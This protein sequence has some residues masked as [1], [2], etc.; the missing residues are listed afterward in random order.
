M[1]RG[2][3]SRVKFGPTDGMELLATG[4]VRVYAAQGR[5]QLYVN[6]LQPLGKGALELALAQLREKLAAEGLFE[7]ARKRAI[8]R[9]AASIVIITSRETAALQDMLKVLRRVPTL[10]VMLFHVPVQGDGAAAKDRGG[11]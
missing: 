9:F 2:E 3:F 8:P 10:R 11:D 6:Q 7:A 5:Y 4:S 1:F